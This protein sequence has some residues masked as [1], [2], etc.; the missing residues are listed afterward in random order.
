VMGP[1]AEVSNKANTNPISFLLRLT[2]G[3]AAKQGGTGTE[4]CGYQGFNT[5]ESLRRDAT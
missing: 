3:E 2:L 4:G 5:R 1:K